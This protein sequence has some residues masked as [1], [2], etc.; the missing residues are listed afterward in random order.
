MWK[1]NFNQLVPHQDISR[2]GFGAPYK[3][4]MCN[5]RR[6]RGLNED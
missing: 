3:G 2:L 5:I 6:V 1:S 4:V